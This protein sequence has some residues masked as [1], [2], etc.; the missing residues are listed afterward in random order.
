VIVVCL[1]YVN[2]KRK[3]YYVR[4]VLVH[5]LDLVLDKIFLLRHASHSLKLERNADCQLH[6]SSR[7]PS[8]QIAINLLSV[9]W[10]NSIGRCSNFVCNSERD[11][12][13]DAGLAF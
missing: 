2:N 4:A 13:L 6:G 3:S 5:S 1:N 9:M 7:K 10:P 12:P 11:A 8:V